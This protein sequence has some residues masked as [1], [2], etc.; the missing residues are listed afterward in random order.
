ML[1]FVFSTITILIPQIPILLDSGQKLATAPSTSDG[2]N[3]TNYR[4]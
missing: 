2:C 4:N 3:L 1:E